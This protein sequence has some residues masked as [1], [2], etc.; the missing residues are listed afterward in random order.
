MKAVLLSSFLFLTCAA[1][2]Y[3]AEIHVA[4]SGSDDN[5]GTKDQPLATLTK[6]R[7][8]VRENLK[9]PGKN[10]ITVYLAE[11]TYR[12][13]EP[14]ILGHD[15][16]AADGRRVTWRNEPGQHPVLS[17]GSPVTGWEKTEL[18]GNIWVADLP[19]SRNALTLYHGDKRL[20]RARGK[21]FASTKQY[22]WHTAPTDLIEFPAGALKNYPDIR[23]AEIVARTTA[24]WAMHIVPLLSVDEKTN[25]ART[26]P[27]VYSFGRIR[28]RE[29]PADS[30][31]VENVLAELDEPGEW[32]VHPDEGK[33]YYWPANDGE[34]ADIIMPLV[35]ELIRVEGTI[36][37]DG[38]A[39]TPVRGLSFQGLTFQHADR[40]GMPDDS[41][42]K[43]LQHAWDYFD[44]PNA[45]LRFR[46]AEDCSVADCR[47]TAAGDNAIRL[48]LHA[49]RIAIE[50]SLFDHLGGAGVVFA[51]YGP[52]T[53]DVNK[54]NTFANNH[55]HH[56]SQIKWDRPAVFVWQSG[57][58]RIRK[59]LIHNIPYIGVSL[60]CRAAFEGKGEGWMTRRDKDITDEIRLHGRFFASYEGW[61]LREK[62]MHARGNLVEENE[63]F[64][65][66]ERMGDGNAIYVSGAGGGNIIR[67]NLIHNSWNNLEAAIRCDDDQHE[68]LIEQNIVFDTG[69]AG[70]AIQLKGRND[71]INNFIV[72]SDQT[73]GHKHYGLIC[74]LTYHPD[75][76]RVEK[77]IFYTNNPDRT[78][79]VFAGE[80]RLL[81]GTSKAVQQLKPIDL[82][83]S[84]LGSNLFWSPR[85]P[86]LR[87]LSFADTTGGWLTPWRTSVI[88][89]LAALDPAFALTSDAKGYVNT[90]RKKTDHGSGLSHRG[91]WAVIQRDFAKQNH[92]GGIL[93]ISFLTRR[94]EVTHPSDRSG[95]FLAAEGGEP[96]KGV[97]IGT[98]ADKFG[99]GEASGFINLGEVPG[100]SDKAT[101]LILARIDL[102]NKIVD[103]WF[104]PSDV[105]SPSALGKSMVSAKIPSVQ[106]LGKTLELRL[107]GQSTEAGIFFDALRLAH[108]S[109]SQA[110][111]AAMVT[112]KAAS[113]V[114]LVSEDFDPSPDMP[115][116]P[117][118]AEDHIMQA[119]ANGYEK[120]SVIADPMFVNPSQKD[121]RFRPGSA[122]PTLGIAP[123]DGRS[124]GL[125]RSEWDTAMAEISKADADAALRESIELGKKVREGGVSANESA[126][127]DETRDLHYIP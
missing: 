86:A 45:M 103:A 90:G 60:S 85:K 55:V 23:H 62:Y 43:G 9:A 7:E 122:A 77:N 81:A 61:K 104:N 21:G 79:P 115:S 44:A 38:A 2:L 29:S 31:W 109:S 1:I 36:D 32:V 93:W 35:T 64:S 68:T 19:I 92:A 52:G 63:F 24:A 74:F 41:L 20:P 107:E 111:F 127:P 39:D 15:D 125:A 101:H 108:G 13:T 96:G 18:P 12:F 87:P 99:V 100:N 66:M 11:G 117:Y 83:L 10:D 37:R 59:N 89:G 106:A 121:F 105:S 57:Q 42:G 53:K 56:V 65:V 114:T 113:D 51:G 3:G 118:W 40:M 28:H 49:Q 95:I 26:K 76:S 25:M 102:A 46:G 17:G 84:T 71:M 6:A 120:G 94:D 116:A 123:I 48:D 124:I 4:P 119:Q 70:N 97:F 50:R 69:S 112:G 67:K 82:S 54:D 98:R 14:L 22:E 5:P 16:A 47:F 33:L 75:G 73:P 58:N 27:G 110:A 80:G 126:V 88:A 78:R 30:L 72:G 8:L 91:Q 34:P